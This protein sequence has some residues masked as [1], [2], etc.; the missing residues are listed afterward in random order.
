[1]DRRHRKTDK[2]AGKLP[3]A[4]YEIAVCVCNLEMMPAGATVR[5]KHTGS[6]RCHAHRPP[7]LG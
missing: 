2:E 1:M 6:Q 5:C 3:K 4:L 7:L